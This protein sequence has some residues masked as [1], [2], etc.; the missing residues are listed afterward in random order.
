VFGTKKLEWSCFCGSGAAWSSPKHAL[1]IHTCFSFQLPF[2]TSHTS[3]TL[4]KKK[5]LYC[6][7]FH[8]IHCDAVGSIWNWLGVSKN[9]QQS[10]FPVK[11]VIWLMI[12]SLLHQPTKHP[13]VPRHHSWC[14]AWVPKL[15]LLF[16]KTPM[17]A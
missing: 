17:E 13:S 1:I 2:S 14:R 4:N 12:V 6:T 3:A 7:A 5:P 10:L 11:D 15:K 9:Y 16:A 8:I